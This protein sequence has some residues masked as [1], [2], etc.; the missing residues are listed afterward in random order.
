MDLDLSSA[1]VLVLPDQPGGAHPHLAV[2]TGKQ[3]ILYLLDRDNM[4]HYNPAG[5][6]QH[7]QE[8]S[9]GIGEV[10]GVPVYWNGKL[11]V[12]G[13]VSPFKAFRLIHGLIATIPVG[14]SATQNQ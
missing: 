12:F 3:G 5:D 14:N 9:P 10:N 13:G 6:T 1:G 11:Y 4:G 2:A 8:L 7:V